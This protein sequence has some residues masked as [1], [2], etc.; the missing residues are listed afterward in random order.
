M[1]GVDKL[2]EL[3]RHPTGH[4][5]QVLVKVL[6][7]SFQFTRGGQGHGGLLPQVG[8]HREQGSAER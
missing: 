7:A 4:L 5:V 8:H 3:W 2:T 1:E 6:A